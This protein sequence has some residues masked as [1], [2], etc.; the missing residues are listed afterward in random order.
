M[1]VGTFFFLPVSE[2]KCVSPSSSSSSSSSSLALPS[3]HLS[4]TLAVDRY[5]RIARLVTGSA[6]G[7]ELQMQ[8][9]DKII[10]VNGEDMEDCDPSDVHDVVRD[11]EPGDELV[12]VIETVGART[13]CNAS[14]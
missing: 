14:L 7:K 9:G 5:P 1:S 12:F 11:T 10:M 2:I 4:S 6:A 3:T 13:W 8:V